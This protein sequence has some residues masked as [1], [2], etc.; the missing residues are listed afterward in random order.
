MDT[1]SRILLRSV[2]AGLMALL[3]HDPSSA[4]TPY[5]KMPFHGYPR[6]TAFCERHNSYHP[7][8]WS[9]AIGLKTGYMYSGHHSAEIGLEWLYLIGSTC[10]P[11]G[12]M[13]VTA[14]TDLLFDKKVVYGPK[15]S[16]EA[17]FM[18]AGARINAT[19]Y[20]EK[21]RE[22][23]LKIRP[24]AGITLLGYVNLFYG[25]TFNLTTPEYYKQKHSISIFGNIP[26]LKFYGHR[27]VR[28]ADWYKKELQRKNP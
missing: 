7:W 17:H 25:Y 8:A 9:K 19:C 15:V 1:G 5:N 21:F 22:G 24:E 11:Y 20:T 6:D 4:Q 23:A 28:G 27:R 14:G 12:T 13:G 18:F 10:D 16:A 2:C 26:L 3:L